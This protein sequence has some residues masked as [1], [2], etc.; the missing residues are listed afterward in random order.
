VAVVVEPG[1]TTAEAFVSEN[2]GLGVLLPLM[3]HQSTAKPVPHRPAHD[4]LA[5]THV[6]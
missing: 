2:E 1:V 4:W 6:P 5:K 3:P